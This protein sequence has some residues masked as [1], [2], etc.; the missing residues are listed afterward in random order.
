MSQL[1]YIKY[2]EIQIGVACDRDGIFA[3]GFRQSCQTTNSYNVHA[4]HKMKVI[5]L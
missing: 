3:R 1:I 2:A 5:D 4:K